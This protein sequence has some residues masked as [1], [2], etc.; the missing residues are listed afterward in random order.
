MDPRKRRLERDE[1]I[2]AS[3]S[4]S[5]ADLQNIYENKLSANIPSSVKKQEKNRS[6]VICLSGVFG[7]Y[8][9]PPFKL[10]GAR[11]RR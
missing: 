8:N 7:T 3:I 4:D 1:K 9:T 10:R 11:F 2:T 5:V 6:S